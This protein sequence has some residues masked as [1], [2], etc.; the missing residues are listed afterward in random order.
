M[1]NGADDES[2][3]NPSYGRFEMLV[4]LYHNIELAFEVTADIRYFDKMSY[5]WSV[6]TVG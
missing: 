2:Y 3:N 4:A 6:T 5:M 1:V